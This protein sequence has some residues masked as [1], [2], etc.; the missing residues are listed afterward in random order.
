MG[1]MVQTAMEFSTNPNLGIYEQDRFNAFVDYLDQAK[2]GAGEND[3]C[4]VV[5]HVATRPAR[6]L[7]TDVGGDAGGGEGE[8]FSSP[9]VRAVFLVFHAGIDTGERAEGGR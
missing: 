2:E 6:G 4:R 3:G 9:V 8:C 7:E 5:E 1:A